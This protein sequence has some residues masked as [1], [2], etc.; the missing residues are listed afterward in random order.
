MTWRAISA[1]PCY[2]DEPYAREVG[3]VAEAAGAA[4]SPEIMSGHDVPHDVLTSV[5]YWMRK[6]TNLVGELYR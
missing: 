1:R 6:A 2:A 5:V 4:T 3:H